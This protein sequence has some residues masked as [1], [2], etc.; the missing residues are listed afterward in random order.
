MSRRVVCASIKIRSRKILEGAKRGYFFAL[1]MPQYGLVEAEIGK[2]G[3]FR[4]GQ[5]AD[6]V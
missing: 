5:L 2:V 6:I 4:R 1:V 3:F